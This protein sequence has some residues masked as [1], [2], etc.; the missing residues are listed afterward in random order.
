MCL[1]IFSTWINVYHV[2]HLWFQTAIKKNN[3][4]KYLRSVGDGETV[5]FDVVEGEKVNISLDLNSVLWLL[6][7][8]GHGLWMSKYIYSVHR[9]Q[10]QQMSPAQEVLLSRAVSTLLTGTATGAIPE[11][12][13]HLVEEIIQRTTRVM[14][15]ASLAAGDVTKATKRGETMPLMETCSNSSAG[16][17]TL[18]DGATRH[19]L[20][21]DA[22]AAGPRTPTHH[23]ERWLRYAVTGLPSW[24]RH[25]V[26][27]MQSQN[28]WL[29]SCP[30]LFTLSS[31]IHTWLWP[32]NLGVS[33]VLHTD[34]NRPSFS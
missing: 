18:G 13:V 33:G 4:R 26:V 3:P 28:T 10:R 12:G 19:T 17:L 22:T 15:R 32:T 23:A 29:C 14:E 30:Q 2:I 8:I 20:Y 1:C 9:E 21:V 25:P 27:P 24:S 16:L 11:G 6:D 31:V 7:Q 34:S 5:E